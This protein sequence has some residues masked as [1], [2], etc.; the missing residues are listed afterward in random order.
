MR[1]NWLKGAIG[2]ALLIVLS[3]CT[4]GMPGGPGEFED[5]PP[6]IMG[7]VTNRVTG[8]RV[9]G[10]IVTVQGKTVA[11]DANGIYSMGGL[12]KERSM[13]EVT[14]AD[15][16]TGR[17]EVVIDRIVSPGDFILEPR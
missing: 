2:V 14:H 13:V 15:Y 10:A 9:S 4:A 5:F 16:V 7:I 17:R 8:A 11:T 3:G 6:G 12:K 1:T